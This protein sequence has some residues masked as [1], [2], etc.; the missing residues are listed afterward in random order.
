MQIQL[1]E[2]I[3]HLPSAALEQRQYPTL[4]P[5]RQVAHTRTT[6]RDRPAA[7]TQTAWL[8]IPVA[9]SARS[10]NP[11]T[12][13]VLLPTKQIIHFLF[14]N[15]LHPSLHLLAKPNLEMLVDAL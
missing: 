9:V 2:Q 5:F 6:H 11:V 7:H 10:V 4:E 14:Q 15:V 8:A 12:S 13:L 3:T 1:G